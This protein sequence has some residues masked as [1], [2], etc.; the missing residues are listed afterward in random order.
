MMAGFSASVA[1]TAIDCGC[2]F[3]DRLTSLVGK[4]G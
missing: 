2:S 4:D 3:S 1:A